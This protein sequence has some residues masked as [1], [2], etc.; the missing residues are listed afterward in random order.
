MNPVIADF[1]VRYTAAFPFAAFH[2]DQQLVTVLAQ[3]AQFIEGR[4]KACCQHATVTNQYRW[5]F[6]DSL[7]QQ[8]VNLRMQTDLFC[9]L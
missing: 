5:L 4:I 9:K 7:Y 1:Q 6:L 8:C 3:F 2:V